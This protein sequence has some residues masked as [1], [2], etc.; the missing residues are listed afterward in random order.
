MLPDYI[1]LATL[2]TTSADAREFA[3]YQA[4]WQRYFFLLTEVGKTKA[5]FAA[6]T[7]ACADAAGADIAEAEIGD[8][9]GRVYLQ[10]VNK[11][12][13]EELERLKKVIKPEQFFEE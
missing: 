8:I 2:E 13:M 5:Q 6:H 1:P 7:A 9:S 10:V 11:T 12:I 4:A 3:F